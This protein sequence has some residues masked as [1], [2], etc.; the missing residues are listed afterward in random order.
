[1]HYQDYECWECESPYTEWTWWPEWLIELTKAVFGVCPR[2]RANP[3]WA[4][5]EQRDRGPEQMH[6]D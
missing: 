2:C 1:M 6:S 5:Q 3:G 4:A